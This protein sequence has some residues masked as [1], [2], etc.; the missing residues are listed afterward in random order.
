MGCSR[1]TTR[2]TTPPASAPS[3]SRT[4]SPGR[5]A[6]A[7]RLRVAE[8]AGR[9]RERREG[10]GVRLSRQVAHRALMPPRLDG[11]LRADDV[12]GKAPLVRG[13]LNQVVGRRVAEAGPARD[14]AAQRVE[15]GLGLAVGVL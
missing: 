9:A 1:D 3:S 5:R 7:Y 14:V 13:P 15:V 12:L 6:R 8:S 4:S 2:S 10:A 11:H